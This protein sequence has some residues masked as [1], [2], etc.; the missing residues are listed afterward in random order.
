MISFFLTFK[1]FDLDPWNL[2]FFITIIFCI[3]FY[4]Y[5]D[6]SGD[7]SPQEED[8]SDGAE[9]D[10][11]SDESNY[12]EQQLERQ[13]NTSVNRVELAP[14]FMQWA[15]RTRESARSSV[16]VPPGSS[17]VFIDPV[18][19]RRSTVPSNSNV[20]TQDHYTMA[21]TASNLAR[22]F[23][24]ILKQVSELL[25]GLNSE[26]SPENYNEE[27]VSKLKKTV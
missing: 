17:L 3:Y 20:A 5:L 10:E 23:S 13:V 7:S 21:T 11:Q 12:N 15:V 2:R 1:A 27:I 14:Q 22:G 25:I 18:A 24:I 8:G 16:R 26:N 9:T 19:L 4:F 6:E